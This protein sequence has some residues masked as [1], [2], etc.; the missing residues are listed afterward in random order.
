MCSF[1]LIIAVR[2]SRRHPSK[3]TFSPLFP[4]LFSSQSPITDYLLSQIRKACSFEA[5][6]RFI[7]PDFLTPSFHSR[8]PTAPRKDNFSAFPNL[9]TLTP[10]LQTHHHLSN[11]HRFLSGPRFFHLFIR[12]AIPQVA[13]NESRSCRFFLSKRSRRAARLW[14]SRFRESF[15][16]DRISQRVSCRSAVWTRQTGQDSSDLSSR[17]STLPY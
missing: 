17:S 10:I 9:E 7:P 11:H 3:T 2:R 6:A 8:T 12:T 14:S 15:E 1:R 16:L 4:S 5:P 13:S